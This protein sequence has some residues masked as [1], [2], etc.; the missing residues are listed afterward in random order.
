[1]SVGSESLNDSP[2]ELRVIPLRHH[3]RTVAAV[4][5]FLLLGALIFSIAT[6]DKI[7]WEIIPKKFFDKRVLHGVQISVFLTVVSMLIGVFLGTLSAIGGM[8]K[9][10]VLRFVSKG[11]VWFFRGTPLVVQILF[12]FN[13]AFF[14]EYIGPY[15]TNDLMTPLV[16]VVVALSL[17]E[18]AYMSEIVRSGIESIDP[19]QTEASQSLGMTPSATIRKVVLPQAMRVIIPPTGNETIS[20]LK[21]TSLVSVIGAVPDLLTAV[22]RIY[23]PTG[24]VIEYLILAS[25]W[26]L[27]MTSVLTFFQTK[28]ERRYGKGFAR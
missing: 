7:D 2:K 1:M 17:N 6:N 3:G 13:L 14:F 5:V 22:Q 16:A 20:M 9:N 23:R 25:I 15:K 8:S 24:E 10:A 21:S 26:Y 19:G 27:L 12:W 28:V 11:F 4:V 18:G